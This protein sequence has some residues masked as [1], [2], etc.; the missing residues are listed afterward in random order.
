MCSRFYSLFQG[1]QMLFRDEYA[2]HMLEIMKIKLLIITHDWIDMTVDV[3]KMDF[4]L[5]IIITLSL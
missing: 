1:V 3:W 2:S 4:H 5:R